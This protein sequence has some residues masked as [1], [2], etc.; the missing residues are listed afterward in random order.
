MSITKTKI[1]EMTLNNPV[2]AASGTFGYGLEFESLTD[3]NKIG[4]I[5]LKGTTLLPKEGNPPQ[6]A[7]STTAGMLNSVGLQNIGIEKLISEKLP[8]LEKFDTAVIINVAGSNIEEYVKICEMLNDQPIVKAVELNISCPNVKKG[9]MAFGSDPAISS[10][11]TKAVK[12]ISNKPVIVKLSPNV[13]D[14]TVIAKA[15]ED[16]G[17]DAV[18]L[19]NTLLGM[20]IDI[21]TRKP[22]L[23]NIFG[24]L[25]GPAIKPVALRMVYSVYKAVSIP[26]IGMGG[27]ANYKDAVEFIL[28]GSSAVSIGTANFYDPNICVE[29]QEG[30]KQYMIENNFEKISDMVGLANVI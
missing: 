26:I 20:A 24:G 25:S 3:I 27:I 14:I 5:C 9:G 6:R 16:A 12:K 23:Q 21:Q 10:E 22:V 18:S 8:L 7:V 2:I 11:L 15:V 1:G 29:V 30:I 19:I 28:A 17:A 4:G 13:T